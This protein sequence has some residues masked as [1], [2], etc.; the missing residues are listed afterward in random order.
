[1]EE[2][3]T[4]FELWAWGRENEVRELKL[5]LANVEDGE[6]RGSSI[7]A[8]MLGVILAGAWLRCVYKS[9]CG[10]VVSPKANIALI[11][12]WTPPEILYLICHLERHAVTRLLATDKN[13]AIYSTCVC[14]AS[15]ASIFLRLLCIFLSLRRPGPMPLGSCAASNWLFP[16]RAFARSSFCN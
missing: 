1:M 13:A 9:T 12:P 4:R 6:R 2:G 11:F 16:R 8:N 5:K 10:A 14:P 7:R 3:I 15:F